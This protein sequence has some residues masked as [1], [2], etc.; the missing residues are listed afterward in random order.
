MERINGSRMIVWLII[1]LVVAASAAS[2]TISYN[3]TAHY[4]R[5]HLYGKK[6][7]PSHLLPGLITAFDLDEKLNRKNEMSMLQ[8]LMVRHLPVV[9]CLGDSITQGIISTNYVNILQKKYTDRFIFV[10]SGVNGNLAYNLNIRLQ[11]DC[12]DFNPDY[13]TIL[14]GTND[15]NS[16]ESGKM[17]KKYRKQQ[18]LPQVPD[19]SFYKDNLRKIIERVKNETRAKIG[20]MSLPLIGELLSSKVNDRVKEYNA[21]IR[22]YA[23]EYGIDYLPLYERQYDY[24][25]GLSDRHPGVHTKKH[26]L[27]TISLMFRRSFDKIAALNGF[28]LSYDGVHMTTT[29]ADLIVRCLSGFLD[30]K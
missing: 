14:I 27:K 22:E 5:I 15:V 18:K 30:E 19:F 2:L 11:P 13:V 25:K 26:M 23:D 24:L 20:I 3:Y 8:V 16:Q 4:H 17:M 12:L 1:V 10:N 29:G 21:L 28:H 9:V 7:K 6:P